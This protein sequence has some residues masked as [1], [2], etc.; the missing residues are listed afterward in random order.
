MYHST[1]YGA[2]L[3]V[4]AKTYSQTDILLDGPSNDSNMLEH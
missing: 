3:R 1:I 2:S 4:E